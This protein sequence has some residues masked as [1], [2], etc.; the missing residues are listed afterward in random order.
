MEFNCPHC[1]KSLLALDGISGQTQMCPY[2]GHSYVVPEP[3]AP[4]AAE[5]APDPP[6]PQQ[7]QPAATTPSEEPLALPAPLVA[8]APPPGPD[9]DA[10]TWAMLCHLSSLC[11]F[12]IPL[13][14]ILGPLVVWLT[15]R[16]KHPFVDDQG[17]EVLNFQISM[18]IY[19]LISALLVLV[20]I[21]FIMLVVVGVMDLVL[22]IM[23][24][25]AANNGR[26]YRYPMTIRF[27]K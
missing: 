4:T 17:K 18:T 23:A 19:A 9:N 2:C 13:G 8:P 26:P 10:R 15:Q 7:P 14:S 5:Q 27:I 21:G 24:A 12:L 25:M 6:V 1:G 11:G 22:T 20:C 3:A 16:E